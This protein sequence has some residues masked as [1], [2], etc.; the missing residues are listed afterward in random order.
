M[1]N[2][3]FILAALAVL[4]VATAAHAQQT[5]LSATVPFTFVVGDRAYPA[6]EYLFSNQDSVLMIR[7][8][9]QGKTELTLSQA[10][11][12]SV[13]SADTRLV[14]DRMGGYY[15]LRQIWVAGNYRGREL[16]R[17]HTEVQLAQKHEQVESVIVA[18]NV[19]R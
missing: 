11:E 13:V 4:L 17:S 1:K 12:N 9:E 7:N 5:R 18:A 19:S 14:F 3:R 10:C 16:P 2:V 6:G 15:F 8:T